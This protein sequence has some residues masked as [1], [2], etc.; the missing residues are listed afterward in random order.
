ME[1]ELTHSGKKWPYYAK[2]APNCRFSTRFEG[3]K[4][5]KW[6]YL[7]EKGLKVKNKAPKYRYLG[8]NNEAAEIFSGFFAY[9]FGLGSRPHFLAHEQDVRQAEADHCGG[10]QSGQLRPDQQQALAQR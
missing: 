6:P 9:D 1:H 8:E 7:P 5:L 3:D 2:V 10:E 4:P